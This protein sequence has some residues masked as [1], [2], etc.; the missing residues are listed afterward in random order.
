[1]ILI[2]SKIDIAT[3][4]RLY[5]GETMLE[6]SITYQKTLRKGEVRALQ[7]TLLAQGRQKLGAAAVEM[8]AIVRGIQD[9][10]RLDRMAARMLTAE[11]W[12][13]LLATP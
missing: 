4:E 3:I 5:Q 10:D 6:D 9:C 2:T 12:D 8:E 13:D 7:R 1:M 11:S